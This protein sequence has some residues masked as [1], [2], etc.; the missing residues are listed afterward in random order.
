M[1]P[2]TFEN[3]QRVRGVGVVVQKWTFKANRGREIHFRHQ[4]EEEEKKAGPFRGKT[5]GLYWDLLSA[6]ELGSMP[7]DLDGDHGYACEGLGCSEQCHQ[8]RGAGAA[9]RW[10]PRR[11]RARCVSSSRFQHE[12]QAGSLPPPRPYPGDLLAFCLLLRRGSRTCDPRD[13]RN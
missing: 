1:R 6:S 9:P 11:Q 13:W 5:G 7:P 10:F 4:L 12:G 3:E 2:V 8:A